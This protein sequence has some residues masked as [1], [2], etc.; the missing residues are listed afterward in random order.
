MRAPALMSRLTILLAMMALFGCSTADGKKYYD[1]VKIYYI[2]IGIETYIPI[3]PKNIELSAFK[4]IKVSYSS[5]Y[6][7]KLIAM[8]EAS[9]SGNF[10]SDHVRVKMLLP[11]SKVIYIDN[12]G[13]VQLVESV[14]LDRK[15]ENSDFRKVRKILESLN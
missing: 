15:L 4:V 2:P 5:D 6:L 14:T 10:S 9:A 1:T 7:K 8:V 13:E 3:T 12:Y 11:D